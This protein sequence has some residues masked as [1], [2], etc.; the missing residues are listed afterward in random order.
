VKGVAFPSSDEHFL[1]G[2][3]DLMLWSDHRFVVCW[4]RNQGRAVIFTE[5][6]E[7]KVNRVHSLM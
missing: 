5:K 3:N 1:R 6:N 2:W 7:K 4:V